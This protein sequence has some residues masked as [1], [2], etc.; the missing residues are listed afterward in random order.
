MGSSI[1]TKIKMLSFLRYHCENNP[2]NT[3]KNQCKYLSDKSVKYEYDFAKNYS[4]LHSFITTPSKLRIEN[5]MDLSVLGE[6]HALIIGN[7]EYKDFQNLETPQNDIVAL[8]QILRN[9]YG[10]KT[11]LIRNSSRRDIIRGIYNISKKVQSDDNFL[12]YYAGHGELNRKTN[13][14][15]W[16]PSDAEKDFPGDW[17]STNEINETLKMVRAKN[18]LVAAD[19]C[20]SGTLTRGIKIE[21]SQDSDSNIEFIKRLHEKRSRI[22]ITSGGNEPVLDQKNEDDMYS[23]FATPLI[24]ALKNNH[25]IVPAH[26]I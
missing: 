5:S 8:D 15:Y 16:I 11:T 25:E 1:N 21:E 3:Y 6:Y 19:S 14:G 24:N 2:I 7:W 18:I 9:K 12:L 13:I 10:F 4:L 22:V 20:Y 17:L 26:N 23:V